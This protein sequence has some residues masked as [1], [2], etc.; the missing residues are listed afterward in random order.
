MISQRR[1][2]KLLSKVR[3]NFPILRTVKIN[4]EIKPLKTGSMYAS[5]RFGYY[6][7]TIDPL[8]YADA[9]D[10]EVIGALAHELMHFETYEKFGWLRYLAEEFAF[11]FSKKLM[12]KY[13]RQNDI[14]TIKRG[15][16]KEIFANRVYRLSKISKQE[17][18]KIGSCYLMPKEIKQYMKKNNLR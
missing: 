3:K 16:G 13:E 1:C 17:Y 7:L 6:V 9:N 2:D 8:K 5:K 11:L 4:L 12:S 10:K 18:K 14:N 15:Y